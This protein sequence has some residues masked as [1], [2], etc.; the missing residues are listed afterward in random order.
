MILYSSEALS[1]IERVRTF[2][3]VKN[4]D[5]AARALRAIRKRLEQVECFPK[6]GKPKGSGVREVVV[7][8]GQRGYIVRYRIEPNGAIYVTRIWARP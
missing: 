6:M 2:L 7:H 1:D 8:F 4:L 5:A 3:E